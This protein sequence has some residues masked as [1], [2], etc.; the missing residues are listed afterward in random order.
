MRKINIVGAS[1]EQIFEQLSEFV[2]NIKE[3]IEAIY[4]G[5]EHHNKRE[6]WDFQ[7]AFLYVCAEQY[8]K[9]GA[10]LMEFGTCWG[11]SAAVIA[12]AAPQASLVTM[13]PNVNHAKISAGQL[14]KHKRVKV[15]CLGS[16]DLLKTYSG[17][18]LDFLFVDGDHDNI[19]L[20]MPW[21]NWIKVGGLM[22]HHD[23]TPKGCPRPTPIV[24]DE[25]V[26]FKAW[27]GRKPDVLMVDDQGTGMA[28]WYKRKGDKSWPTQPQQN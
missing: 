6:I 7:A 15:L 26:R 24:Y 1:H 9:D 20:D 27:I 25:L 3:R 22:L 2:P 16:V 13:T 19:A 14:A 5:M 28:G 18:E 21:W 4:A 17:P 8:N 12:S 11:W 23:F 10:Q